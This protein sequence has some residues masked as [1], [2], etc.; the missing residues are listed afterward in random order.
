MARLGA[1]HIAA[2]LLESRKA[3]VWTAEFVNGH[4]V[5]AF[6]S[7]ELK[8]DPIELRAGEWVVMEVSPFDL[9]EG[10]ILGKINKS[11]NDES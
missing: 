9:S 11:D 6:F 10:C 7:P 8:K 4:C 3:G 5:V 2:K 1:I